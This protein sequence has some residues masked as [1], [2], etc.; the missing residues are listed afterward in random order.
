MKTIISYL[1]ILSLV[2]WIGSLIFIFL[3]TRS[4]FSNLDREL[5][6]KVVGLVFPLY[7]YLAYI[8]ALVAILSS[9]Y[10]GLK[11]NRLEQIKLGILGFMLVVT[12]VSGLI[13]SPKARS[14]KEKLVTVTDVTEKATLKKQFGKTHGISVLLN[15][16]VFLG[17]LSAVYVLSL[18]LKKSL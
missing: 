4:F 9:L 12:L 2:A 1:H 14:I 17:G 16:L 6:G 8:S 3:E 7:H 18:Q 5:A 13:I 15:S 11:E 10:F